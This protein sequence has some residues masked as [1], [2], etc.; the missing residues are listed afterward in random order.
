M[1][2]LLHNIALTERAISA[3]GVETYD[4]PVN[5][6]SVILLTL[7]PLNNTGT[8]SN[9]A[10]YRAICAALNRV[11]VQFRGENIISMRG[12]DMAALNFYRW[13]LVPQEANPDNVDDERRAVVLPIIMG[14]WPYDPESC[15]PG[16]KR[17]E[18]TLECDYDIADTGYDGLRVSAETVEIIGANP[19]E[20]EKRVQQTFTT[21]ATGDT[22]IDLPMGHL[23]RGLLLWGT[24]G[25]AGATPAPSWGRLKLMMDNQETG[26]AN[27]DW[28]VLHM[29]SALHGR[30]PYYGEHK[31]TVNAAGA[32]V[33]E[34]TSVFDQGEDF[35]QYS[36]MDLDPLRDDSYSLDTK[37]ANS[38]RIRYSAET[39]DAVRVVPVEVVKV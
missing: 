35:T 32:G 2:K 23:L 9:Y 31:H 8:L 37:N 39:A 29:L 21:P 17:G 27:A 6:L 14:K 18:L 19:K 24:T 11:S 22:D 33:E 28:E 4:L 20:Y 13:G 7:R 36:Y 1:P 16:T 26:Y 34:T 5:P 25:Y 15:F 10:R 3:D 30:Q 12:E 38:L